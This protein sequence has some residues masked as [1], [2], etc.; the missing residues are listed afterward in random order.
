MGFFD[1][2][3]SWNG[4]GDAI[5]I[6]ATEPQAF[7]TLNLSDPAVV[8]WLRMGNAS[9][10]G[11]SVTEKAALRN[12]TFFRAVNLISGSI[13][14]LPTNL[15]RKLPGGE[16]EKAEAHPVHRLLRKRPNS[17]QTPLQFK[18]FMQG[19]ALLE[20]DAFAY[21]L[22]GARGIQELIP[23]DPRR[24]KPELSDDWNL[25]YLW[26]K[27]DGTQRRL[28]QDEVFHLRAPFSEDGITG[29]GLLD[30]AREAIG[31]AIAADE[32]AASLLKNGAFP[33]GKLK[34]PKT[35]S[36]EAGVRL[37]EQF[38]ERFAG[39]ENKGKW[40]L[41]EEG[42]DAEP[43]GMTGQEAEGLGQRKHQ[44]EEVSRY[45]GVP[46]P[47]LMFD[48][49]SWGSG[50]EQLGLFLIT[51]CLMPWFVAWEEV[52]AQSLLTQAERDGGYYAK[53]NEA[54]L[55][56]GSLKDQ[57]EFFAKAL[58]GPGATG[59]MMPNEAREKMDMNPVPGGDEP[60]W[61]Q[62]AGGTGN[63]A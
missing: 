57:A 30:V 35:L 13:G 31:L 60:N 17:W 12:S 39:S 7:N 14:M 41:I 19:R 20:G 4:T 37:R 21:K 9:A 55:L 47:L 53:F 8:E 22:P 3:F 25:T 51:Y 11:K 63:A 46:R 15:H 45:T 44:A 24:V 23:L 6:P 58:G 27:K 32:S 1:R 49:T 28:R 62:A 16:T 36:K 48:E 42:M 33:G 43:L 34:H 26:T 59:F 10:A 56:R 61:G 2:L 52:I 5:A 18:A 54:A 40:I 29:A 38:E 50:I